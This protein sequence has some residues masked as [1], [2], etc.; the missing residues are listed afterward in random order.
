MEAHQILESE[1]VIWIISSVEGFSG[2]GQP[3]GFR[4][5]S[6]QPC[7]VRSGE[8]LIQI[9]WNCPSP[10]KKLG[11]KQHLPFKKT[12]CCQRAV[13]VGLPDKVKDIAKERVD[14]CGETA[15]EGGL[16]LT[17]KE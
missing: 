8:L 16:K 17:A 11:E 15:L 3:V 4:T 6:D 9:F 1:F 13:P 7:T 12:F 5:N 10:Q 14:V 2:N